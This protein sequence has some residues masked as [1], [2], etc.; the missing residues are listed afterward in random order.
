M[1]LCKVLTANEA[2]IIMNET[3]FKLTRLSLDLPIMLVND[4]SLHHF[5]IVIHDPLLTHSAKV[6][7]GIREQPV[8]QCLV[9]LEL[10]PREASEHLLVNGQCF[11][12]LT[13]VVSIVA[14]DFGVVSHEDEGADV[15]DG[16]QPCQHVIVE[17]EGLL[18]D[19]WKGVQAGLPIVD[20]LL[21]LAS[22][23]ASLW[24]E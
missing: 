23:L 6:Q 18:Q 11:V 20:D 7:V 4:T 14:L 8:P 1:A 10:Q 9:L 17:E 2:P 15:R 22:F 5:H 13:L 16:P 21:L 19:P 24:V 3:D 12:V